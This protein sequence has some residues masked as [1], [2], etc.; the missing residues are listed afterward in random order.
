MLTQ[1][2]IQSLSDADLRSLM[3]LAN[4]EFNVRKEITNARKLSQFRSGDRVS[5]FTN[6]NKT[7]RLSGT[8]IRKMVKNVEIKADSGAKWTVHPSFI[9]NKIEIEIEEESPDK[10]RRIE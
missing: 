9:I 1:A 2:E 7:E 5:F 10:K 3:N 6:K 8:L 4:T